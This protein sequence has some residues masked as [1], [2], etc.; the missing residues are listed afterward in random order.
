MGSLNSARFGI[1]FLAAGQA[2]KELTH[3]EALVRIDAALHASVESAG[4]DT[5]VLDPNPGLCWIVG[6]SPTGAWAGQAG[7][8]ACWTEAGWRF[9]P[10]LEGTSAWLKDEQLWAVRESGGWV[11]GHVR[12]AR[13][14]VDGQQVIGSRGAAV[15][16]PVGGATVDEEARS[17]IAAILDRLAEHGLIEA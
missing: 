17:A 2:Q 6:N 16:A 8:I 1:P 4:L 3:N 5:P 12:A 11:I 9:V 13:V 7:A 10:A 14:S 15:T